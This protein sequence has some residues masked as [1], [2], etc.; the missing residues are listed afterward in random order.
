MQPAAQQT[1]QLDKE[2]VL[3][4]WKLVKSSN[5]PQQMF[6]QLLSSNPVLK[7]TVDTINAM[8]NPEKLFYEIAKQQGT[9]P[10]TVLSLLK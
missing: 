9:D 5:N 10:N 3:Q 2:K 7:Q 8:G 1:Q 6:E 4:L